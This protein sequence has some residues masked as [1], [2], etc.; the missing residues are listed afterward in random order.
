METITYQPQPEKLHSDEITEIAKAL[1]KAQS[2]TLLAAERGENEYYKSKYATLT[3]VWNCARKA[4]TSNGLA[5]TQVTT[6]SALGPCL[7]TILMHI[8]GQWI[9]STIRISPPKM[10]AQDV[11]KYMTYMKRYSLCAIVGI[12]PGEHEDDG[13]SLMEDHK[14]DESPAKKEMDA[15]GALREALQEKGYA[16]GFLRT[17]LKNLVAKSKKKLSITEMANSAADNLDLFVKGYAEELKK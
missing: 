7:H 8:S 13:E 14:V 3:E 11:G 2:S 10:T 15:M 4:L 1:S 12:S 16:D 9:K 5:V 6:E 17:Y